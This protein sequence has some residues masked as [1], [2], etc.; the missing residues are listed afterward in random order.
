MFISKRLV[1]VYCVLVSLVGALGLIFI[2]NGLGTIRDYGFGEKDSTL[3][4]HGYY[5]F[6]IGIGMTVTSMLLMIFYSYFK[7][8]ITD[9]GTFNNDSN[10]T[11]DIPTK[12]NHQ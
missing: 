7:Q 4:F 1:M 10:S 11:K 12:L 8:V 2:F 3:V 6:C 5:V 9:L